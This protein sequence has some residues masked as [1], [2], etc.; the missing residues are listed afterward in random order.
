VLGE[1]LEH[2]IEESDAGL[3]AAGGRT[4]ELELQLDIG[5]AR[6]TPQLRAAREQRARDRRPALLRT[7]LGVGADA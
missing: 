4:V 3:D 7:G 5:F 2:V 6:L 1:L